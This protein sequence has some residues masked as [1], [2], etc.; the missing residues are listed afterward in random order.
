[1]SRPR[2]GGVGVAG[3]AARAAAAES[4][5]QTGALLVGPGIAMVMVSLIIAFDL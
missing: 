2:A 5:G 3:L 1:M 4:A